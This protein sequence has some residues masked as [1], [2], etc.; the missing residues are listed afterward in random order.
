[1]LRFGGI[2]L[3]SFQVMEEE[4]PQQE[5]TVLV[6]S[7][8]VFLTYSVSQNLGWCREMQL[9]ALGRPMFLAG[10][11]GRKPK[12]DTDRL[13][14]VSR[15]IV[16]PSNCHVLP[17]PWV[18]KKRHGLERLPSLSFPRVATVRERFCRHLFSTHP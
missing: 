15:F 11:S 7:V 18:V 1:M 10:A 12:R 16:L 2:S 9:S 14:P 5:E 13:F 6:F 4:F 3:F 8:L 17:N